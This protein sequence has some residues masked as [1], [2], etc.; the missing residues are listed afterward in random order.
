MYAQE[1]HGG[2]KTF[3]IRVFVAKSIARDH[4]LH[5]KKRQQRTTDHSRAEEVSTH[6]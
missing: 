2:L 3:M 4:R 5:R 6:E 1:M